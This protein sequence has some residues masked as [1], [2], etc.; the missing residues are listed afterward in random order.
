[1]MEAKHKAYLEEL[2][3]KVDA[4]LLEYVQVT[5]ETRR[6]AQWW[7]PCGILWKPAAS[8][9]VRCWCWNS[10]DFWRHRGTGNGGGVCH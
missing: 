8:G 7:K 4:K 6:Q 3:A 10:A 2:A 1:M 5:P 9:S